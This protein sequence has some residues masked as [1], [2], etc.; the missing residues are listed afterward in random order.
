MKK[1]KMTVA[2]LVLVCTLSS[3]GR[4]E[5]P[6]NT[7][8]E[9]EGSIIESS[10]ENPQ[11]VS[12]KAETDSTKKIEEE[13]DTHEYEG[14]YLANQQE[15]NMQDAADTGSEAA[16]DELLDSFINGQVSAVDVADLTSTFYITDL[17]MDSEEWDSYSVGEKVDLDNDG[18]NELI[19]NGPYGGIYLDARD[20]RVYEFA[21]GGGT[22]LRLS[23]TVYS[24]AVWIMYSNS[25]NA[26]YE[27]YH[28]EKFE[29]ADN[30]VAEMNFSEEFID[31]NNSESGMKYI[32]N[33]NEISYDEYA[34]LCSRIF[35]AEV[36]TN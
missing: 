30:L 25:M 26:G 22:A 10:E 29:G 21:A 35:A 5:E 31:E 36:S 27:C 12:D 16:A 13:T 34:A 24:G 28:M 20:N 11:A 18:E 14:E 15:S 2:M 7:Q 32:L 3:C 9:A 19:I 4:A 1:M 6:G 17:N 8:M 33:G 23:Y